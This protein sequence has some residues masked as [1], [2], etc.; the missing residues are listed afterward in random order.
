VR[1]AVAAEKAGMKVE[2]KPL[3]FSVPEELKEKF[4]NDPRF[5]RAFEALT[6]GRQRGIPVSLRR[7]EA[8]WD[9]D[10]ADREGD[11]SDLR[12]TRVLGAA[13]DRE[14]VDAYREIVLTAVSNAVGNSAPRRAR[15][16]LG[17]DAEELL[18]HRFGIV[19]VWRPIRGPVQ[20]SPLHC[21]TRAASPTTI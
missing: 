12:R 4:R 21:A 14:S 13:I 5:K 10:R 20:D 3:E 8:V 6:P 15:D 1:E 19:N 2:M 17:A 9:A 11:A 7:R 18:K 16:H